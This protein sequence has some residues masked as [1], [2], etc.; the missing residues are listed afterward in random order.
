MEWL[1]L[2]DGSL[3]PL[4][5]DESDFVPEENLNKE[6]LLYN[7]A[8]TYGRFIAMIEVWHAVLVSN[9]GFLWPVHLQE[10]EVAIIRRF[11]F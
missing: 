6:D 7:V 9:D 5:C 1:G 4:I 2:A 3:V 8:N 11:P 10:F